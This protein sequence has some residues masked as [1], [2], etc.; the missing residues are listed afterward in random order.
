M[1]GVIHP[2]RVDLLCRREHTSRVCQRPVLVEHDGKEYVVFTN[3]K[4]GVV[5]RK[6]DVPDQ[7]ETMPEPD[8]PRIGRVFF[9]IIK[10]SAAYPTYPT[11]LGDLRAWA[12]PDDVV[13]DCDV[14]DGVGTH[15]CDCGDQHTCKECDGAGDV[16]CPQ[17]GTIWPSPPTPAI[18]RTHLARCLSLLD[19]PDVL[20]VKLSASTEPN[21]IE[22]L[23]I[24]APYWRVVVMPARMDSDDRAIENAFVRGWGTS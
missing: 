11:T 19:Q 1:G 5:V 3:G 16:H 6:R 13:A 23:V 14:C 18:D 2:G 15:Y 21:A 24:A 4:C 17:W 12:G 7:V 22:P 9:D 20:A 10:E 8:S